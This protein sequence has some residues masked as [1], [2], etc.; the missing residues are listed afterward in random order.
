MIKLDAN[1]S[2]F[3]LPEALRPVLAAALAKVELNRYPDGSAETLQRALREALGLPDSMGLVLGNGSDELLQLITTMVAKPGAVVLAPEPTFVMYAIYASHSAIRYV[4]VP[5]NRELE[6]DV[7]AMHDAIA[8]EHP[9]LVW[10]A[11]PNNPTGGRVPVAGIESILQAAPGLVVVDEAYCA[12]ADES[13][14]ARATDFPNLVV[15]RTL[16]KT[17]LAGLRLGLA[18]G[19]LAWTRAIETL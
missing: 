7:A 5:L 12:Y 18:A 8:R 13:M 2:P 19:H 9:A 15:T 4:G 17:G 14:L 1:E 6:L 11:S 16:S 10:L 3:A